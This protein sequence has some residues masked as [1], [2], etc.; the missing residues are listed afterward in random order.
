[1]QL[2][3]NISYLRC[4]PSINKL[5][6]EILLSNARRF[7]SS[8]G[9][10]LGC[11]WCQWVNRNCKLQKKEVNWIFFIFIFYIQV[12]YYVLSSKK[13]ILHVLFISRVK[14]AAL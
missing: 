6:C 14:R 10:F 9:C 7:Y 8:T 11:L 5:T 4:L 1:M 3:T 2:S 13:L 12:N